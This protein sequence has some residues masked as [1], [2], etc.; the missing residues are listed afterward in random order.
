MNAEV[1]AAQVKLY[2]KELKMP[3]LAAAFEEIVRDGTKAGRVPRG[4]SGRLPAPPRSPR[5][6]APPASR[7]KAAR[8]PQR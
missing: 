6:R 4:L 7:I 2:A 5:A 8:F 1:V 3:G